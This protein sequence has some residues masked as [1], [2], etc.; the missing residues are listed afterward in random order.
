MKCYWYRIED[1]EIKTCMGVIEDIPEGY[2]AMHNSLGAD[3]VYYKITGSKIT[4]AI[5]EGIS[6]ETAHRRVQ[7]FMSALNVNLF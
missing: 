1:D 4:D 5:G 3:S 7:E 2:I 6:E